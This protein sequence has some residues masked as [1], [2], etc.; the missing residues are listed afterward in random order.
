MYPY[1]ISYI[2]RKVPENLGEKKNGVNRTCKVIIS[3][4]FF[5]NKGKVGDTLE[6]I[7]ESLSAMSVV[8]DFLVQIMYCYYIVNF[9]LFMASLSQ[10]MLLHVLIKCLG[11]AFFFN[12]CVF[13][14]IFITN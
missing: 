12:I 8:D 14:N 13:S 4:F 5:F 11:N 2:A 6:K 1:T 10:A 7:I 9:G 3:V